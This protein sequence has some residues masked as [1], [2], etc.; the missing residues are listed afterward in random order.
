MSRKE[1]NDLNKNLLKS[2]DLLTR[3][4]VNQYNLIY[5]EN[6]K[7]R[8]K[9]DELKESVKTLRKRKYEIQDKNKELKDIVS[10]YEHKEQGD[11]N[12]SKRNQNEQVQVKKYR[13]Y[14]ETKNSYNEREITDKL[15]NI[16]TIENI[17]QLEND[18]VKLR[19]NEEL[20]RLFHLIPPLKDLDKMIGLET[21]KKEVLKKIIYYIQNPVNEE[22]LHTIISGPPGV[23]KTQFAKIYAKIFVHLGILKNFKFIEVKRDQLVGEYLGQ[24]APRTRAVLENGLGGVIFIDEAYSLGNPEKR[25]SF[26]KE[27]IDMINQYLSEK[28]NE[29]MMIVAGYE[30]EL[31]ESF[32]SFNPGLERRFSTHYN[33]EGYTNQELTKI[34]VLKINEANYNN[35]IPEKT[36][37]TFFEKNKDNFKY[38][39]GSVEQLINEIKYAHSFRTFYE[40]S[41]SRDVVED[42]LYKAY[43]TYKS[44]KKE[45]KKEEPPIGMYL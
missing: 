41:K 32:F 23:G 2:I 43:E 21:I 34:M 10:Y 12:S 5:Q 35:Q 14:K 1:D 22:Y 9:V 39:G 6:E 33:I 17:L 37:D 15:V 36:L 42:D 31:K 4:S 26:S 16:K 28:K 45:K 20:Q 24:T 11:N 19:H 8:E 3:H 30:K 38:F 40:N 27:S 29:F 25:D 44:N 7:L 13:K 18:W